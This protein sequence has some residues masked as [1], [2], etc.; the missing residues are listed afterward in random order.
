MVGILLVLGADIFPAYGNQIV[1]T[2]GNYHRLLIRGSGAIHNGSAKTVKVRDEGSHL[3]LLGKSY[4]TSTISLDKTNYRITVTTQNQKTFAT[5]VTDY[6]KGRL[7]LQFHAGHPCHSISGELLRWSDWEAISSLASDSDGCYKFSANIAPEIR[8]EAIPA[9]Q[10]RISDSHWGRPRIHYQAEPMVEYP[11][12]AKEEEAYLKRKLKPWGLIPLFSSATISLKPL[13]RIKILVAEINRQH[14]TSLGISWPDSYSA[15][16]LPKPK[17]NPSWDVEI[18][19]LLQ[20]GWGKVLAS[21]NLL[22]RSGDPAEF[23]AGGEVPLRLSH[24]KTSRISWKKYG[25]SLKVL[26]STDS[27]GYLDVNLSAEVSNPDPGLSLE[28]LPAFR[29]HRIQS[30]F[31]LTQKRTIALAGLIRNEK[32]VSK[33]GWPGLSK[34][35]ILGALFSSRNFQENR[36]ELVILVTPEVVHEETEQAQLPMD[37][38]Q[39]EQ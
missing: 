16:L 38:N 2:K 1:I 22:T 9:L 25:I 35:P 12:T 4:G 27:R 36:S 34:I 37:W 7:G 39:N 29:T 15:K 18:R 8:Q 33:T 32:G 3:R 14:M 17:I 30:H 5:A 28:G 24:Y 21:P 11:I 26:A 20:N 13:I 10:A 31:N 19:A 23:L 6:L